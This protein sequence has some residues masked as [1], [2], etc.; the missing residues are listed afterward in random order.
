[1]P[2]SSRIVVPDVPHHVIQR[3]NRQQRI[4]LDDEDRRAYVSM[5]ANSLTKSGTDCLA[6]CLMDNHIHLILVPRVADGLR[7]PLASTHTNFAQWINRKY[8]VSGHLFQGRFAS[9]AMDDAHCMVAIR[10]IETNPV[11][12]GLVAHGEDW[13]WSSARAH[14]DQG[15]DAL[16][17]WSALERRGLA[18]GNWSGMLANGLEAAQEIE[19]AL[20]SGRPRAEADWLKAKQSELDLAPLRRKGRPRKLEIK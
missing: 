17:S 19:T 15:A 5:L 20:K 8:E 18:L 11:K 4:F 1:M 6:W 12:A 14:I 16:T 13:K 10:Y 3:G 9:Y 2:R 7:A